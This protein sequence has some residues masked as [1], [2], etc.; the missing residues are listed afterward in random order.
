MKRDFD[1]RIFIGRLEK[2][3]DI[4]AFGM[5]MFEV[6]DVYLRNSSLLAKATPSRF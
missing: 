6:G 4:Y 3:V 2:P 1:S 5:T